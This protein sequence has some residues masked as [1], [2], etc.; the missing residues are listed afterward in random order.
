MCHG[1][2]CGDQRWEIFRDDDDCQ[3]SLSKPPLLHAAISFLKT[4]AHG[5][6]HPD[7]LVQF[8][9]AQGEAME[10][11]SNLFKQVL[12]GAGEQWIFGCGGTHAAAIGQFQANPPGFHPAAADDGFG[13]RFNDHAF[14]GWQLRRKL[15]MSDCRLA[16]NGDCSAPPLLRVNPISFPGSA[17]RSWGAG[18]G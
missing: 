4:S 10:A 18:R 16:R 17:V 13:C 8:F 11:Q 2:N 7:V 3:R 14:E 5:V 12:R 6:V 1:M 9:P 15:A